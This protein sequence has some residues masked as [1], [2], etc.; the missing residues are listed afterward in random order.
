MT[1]TY[2]TFAAS[3]ACASQ[4]KASTL[5]LGR[6][7]PILGGRRQRCPGLPPGM[8]ARLLPLTPVGVRR[9]IET[10]N[11]VVTCPEGREATQASPSPAPTWGAAV[12]MAAMARNLL[13]QGRDWLLAALLRPSTLG[14]LRID[15]WG[16]PTSRC[17]VVCFSPPTLRGTIWSLR[18]RVCLAAMG[19]RCCPRS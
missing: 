11:S 18:D 15:G 14:A 17:W 19:R 6:F 3:Y 7:I 2:P 4:A 16:E 8:K 10:W 5:I 13:C 1:L 9:S 12:L